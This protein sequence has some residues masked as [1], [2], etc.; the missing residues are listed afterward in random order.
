MV[1]IQKLHLALS[2]VAIT[3]EQFEFARMKFCMKIN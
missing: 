2:L 3:N 1:T